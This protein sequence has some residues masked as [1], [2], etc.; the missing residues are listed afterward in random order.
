MKVR[1]MLLL[2]LLLSG[3]AAPPAEIPISEIDRNAVMRQQNTVQALEYWSLNGQIALFNLAA[4]ER[5]AVYLEWQQTPNRMQLRFYHPLKGTLARLKQDVSGA[6][7]FAE[8]GQ[9]Y[10][11]HNAEELVA[12]LFNYQLPL[13]LLADV[14]IGRQPNNAKHLSYQLV[15]L[16]QQSFAPLTSYSV[17]TKGQ[18]WRVDLAGYQVQQQLLLP[19]RVELVSAKWRIKLRVSQW[20]L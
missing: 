11:G 2:A 4:D 3:C 20:K 15:E 7:Y 18:E 1:L 8:D 9:V 6:T 12:R 17:N 16:E 19:Q 5:D 14:V 13:E 10:H